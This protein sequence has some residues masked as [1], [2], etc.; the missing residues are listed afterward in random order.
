MDI[1]LSRIMGICPLFKVNTVLFFE[2]PK[3]EMLAHHIVPKGWV[4]KVCEF[5]TKQLIKY[6][7]FTY[8]RCRHRHTHLCLVV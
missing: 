1:S 8:H 5:I 6:E 2:Q 7:L 3:I 4:E